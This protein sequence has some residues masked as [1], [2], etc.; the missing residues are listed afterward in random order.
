MTGPDTR[1]TDLERIESALADGRATAADPRER[2]LQELALAL[3]ADAP[4]PAP[5]FAATM[6]R[7]LAEGF[8]KPRRPR[9][10][11]PSFFLPAF[12][13]AAVLI[14]VAVVTISSIGG[15]DDGKPGSVASS[16][17]PKQG[18]A[19]GLNGVTE[20]PG[21]STS[22]FASPGPSALT[23]GGRHVERSVELTISTAGDKLQ[24]AADGVGTVAE[25]H[26]G[27][28]L[29]SHVNTSD[30]GSSG[31]DF[32]LR[33]PQRELQSTV[34][35]ISKL[36]HLRARSE[37]GQDMTAPYN[38]VQDRLGN[39]LLERRTLTLKLRH[40]HGRRAEAIRIRLATLNAA[41]DSLDGRMR[42]LKQRTVFS[43]INVTLQ[44]EKDQSGGTG[45]AWDDAQR[46]LEGMLNFGVRAFAVL[47]P[48]MLLGGIAGL[49][50]RTLR[51]RRREAPLL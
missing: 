1:D 41:I 7:R 13:G 51:R 23:A 12:A 32:T 40:A 49:A 19:R 24:A 27:F 35:D 34:A 15:G 20:P 30:Q 39:A 11:L 2:E 33:V 10:S 46:T 3:R 28:V 26:G 47:L 31:G 17:E 25:S 50:G 36:G 42:D 45:A 29:R 6:D 4:E 44:Q 18:L 14:V 38:S 21:A 22:Q 48:L 5:A 9:L 43:T 8:G 16:G 37:S